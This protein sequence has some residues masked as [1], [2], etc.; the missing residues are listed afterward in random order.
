VFSYSDWSL[1]PI[2]SL[3]QLY[4]ERA[5]QLRDKYSY[6]ILSVSGGSDSMNMLRAFLDNG[7][8][9]DE[10]VTWYPVAAIEKLISTFDHDKKNPYNV[11]FEYITAF[12]PQ[13][14]EISK[15]HPSMKVT[16]LDH[17]DHAL[18]IIGGANA[19]KFDMAGL[20]MGPGTAGPLSLVG[21]QRKLGKPNSAIIT[22]IDKPRV[23]YCPKT[24]RFATY[25]L[26]FHSMWGG[27][28]DAIYGGFHP[29]IEY[30]YYAWEFPKLIKKQSHLIKKAVTPIIEG[31]AAS[32]TPMYTD[33]LHPKRDTFPYDIFNV[34]L[35][36][37]ERLIYPKTYNPNIFQAEKP[38]S[39]LYAEANNWFTDSHLTDQKIKSFYT[40][41]IQEFVSDIAKG[42]LHVT[43]EGRIGG[44]IPFGSPLNFF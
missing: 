26:D 37:F 39:L 4:A 7:L 31:E 12:L 33:L 40:G 35:D 42:F 28:S 34:Q 22:G 14:T 44:F 36:F 38:T 9:V 27:V 20:T 8:P 1:E 43:K 2:E 11:M 16:V 30:F 24:K 21:Y 17:T 25:F 19:H 6:L 3:E 29:T 5:K 23:I 15:R 41:Q 10:V 32:N 18:T 13:M